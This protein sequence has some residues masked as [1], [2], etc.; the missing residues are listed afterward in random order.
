LRF[1]DYNSVYRY[2]YEETVLLTLAKVLLMLVRVGAILAIILGILVL[3]GTNAQY[4]GV[5]MWLGFFLTGLVVILAVM[6]LTKGAVGPGLVGIVFACLLPYV[7]VKQIPLRFG[8]HLGW[9]Q[10]VHVIIALITVGT[11]E[12]LH[13]AIKKAQ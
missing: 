7:G 6:A 10:I 11:A 8:F 4:L 3:T 9:V 12:M 5:H 2:P 13:G 1:S